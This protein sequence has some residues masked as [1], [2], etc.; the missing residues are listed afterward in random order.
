MVDAD[1]DPLGIIE[2]KRDGCIFF[3]P[4]T[5]VPGK[6]REISDEK[7]NLYINYQGA[8]IYGDPLLTE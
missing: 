7:V 5:R 1:D 4:T 6:I 3:R 8:S 2:Y